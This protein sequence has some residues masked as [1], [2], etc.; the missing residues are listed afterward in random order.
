GLAGARISLLFGAPERLAELDAWPIEQTVTAPSL[1]AAEIA[2]AH[3]HVF[4]QIWTEIRQVREETAALLR[5]WGLGPLPSG[6]NFLT[7]RVGDASKAARLTRR[8]G[9][10]GYRIRDVSDLA[11]LEGCIR[12]TLGDGE[13]THAFLRRLEAALSE[14]RH[15][16]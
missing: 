13:T 3:H 1:L 4:Q 6:G 7:V 5:G 16:P 15:Q 11:G 10:D 8:L 9:E 14:Q 12:F 2:T